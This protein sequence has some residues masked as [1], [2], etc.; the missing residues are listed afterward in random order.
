M[1]LQEFKREAQRRGNFYDNSAN[2]S[3]NLAKSWGFTYHSMLWFYKDYTIGNMRWKGGNVRLRNGSYQS[4]DCFIGDEKV[5][6][7]R[8]KKAL[9][10]FV[11]PPLTDEEQQHIEAEQHHQ[12]AIMR[13]IRFKASRRKNRR[14]EIDPRQLSI[15]FAV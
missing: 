6:E 2:A 12:E 10:T 1:T 4:V 15:N 13:E 14:I 8:F 5:S 3:E 9:E 7:Y 11:F